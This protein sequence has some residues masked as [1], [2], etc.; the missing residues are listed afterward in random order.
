MAS[1]LHLPLV[2]SRWGDWVFTFPI[3]SPPGVHMDAYPL[4]V[5]ACMVLSDGAECVEQFLDV[6]VSERLSGYGSIPI[7]HSLLIQQGENS[8]VRA[9]PL[10]LKYWGMTSD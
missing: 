8:T 9:I 5:S 2:L 4:A 3:A 7:T 1:P 10:S 6:S